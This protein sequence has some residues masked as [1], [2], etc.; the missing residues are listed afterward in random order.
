MREGTSPCQTL[1][2]HCADDR[3]EEA[4]YR[5]VYVDRHL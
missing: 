2:P 5:P 4:A 1:S 3:R